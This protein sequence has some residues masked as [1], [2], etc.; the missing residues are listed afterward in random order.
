MN[1]DV[2]IKRQAPNKKISLSM[3]FTFNRLKSVYKVEES[4]VGANWF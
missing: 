4:S 2:I 3:D 1:I